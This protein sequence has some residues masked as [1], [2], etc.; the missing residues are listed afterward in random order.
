MENLLLIENIFEFGQKVD[1]L[2]FYNSEL[3]L[4]TKT[5]KFEKGQKVVKNLLPSS[6]C[7]IS[8]NKIIFTPFLRQKTGKKGVKK[9]KAMSGRRKK[10]K[11]Q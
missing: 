6:S 8:G 4:I 11:P 7:S 1:I 9:C 3:Q 2:F 5:R 10:M